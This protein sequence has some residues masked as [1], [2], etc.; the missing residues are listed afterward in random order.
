[1]AS[2]IPC[3]QSL[4]KMEKGVSPCEAPMALDSI[5]GKVSLG[6]G[7]IRLGIGMCSLEGSIRL[8]MESVRLWF[9]YSL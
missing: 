1:M 3:V 6:F 4:R 2:T 5:F 9:V 7:S 8:G